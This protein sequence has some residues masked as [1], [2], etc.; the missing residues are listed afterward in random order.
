MV[1]A[2]NVRA[3]RWPRRFSHRR[4]ED[5]YIVDIDGTNVSQITFTTP[6]AQ[7]S[8]AFRAEASDR[9]TAVAVALTRTFLE[10]S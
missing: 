3:S 4:N 2:P 5:I 10:K 7:A 8:A 9:R 1:S 6:V